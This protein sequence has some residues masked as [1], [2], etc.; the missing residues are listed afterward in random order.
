MKMGYGLDESVELGPMTTLNGREQV[1]GF[2][3]S[4]LRSGAK[5]LLDGRNAKV[6]GY[7]EGYFL[8]PNIFENVSPQCI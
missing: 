7:E 4:G 2:I 6:K 5:L 8:G 1:V 3:E